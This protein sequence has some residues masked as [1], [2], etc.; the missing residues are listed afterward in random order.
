LISGVIFKLES[1][2]IVVAVVSLS[3]D[4]PM[5][6]SCIH[7]TNN[8]IS[9]SPL[10]TQGEMPTISNLHTYAKNIYYV[11]YASK[12]SDCERCSKSFQNMPLNNICI[13]LELIGY[14]SL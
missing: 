2:L 11:R 1:V 8:R 3:N 14:Y 7:R 13:Y 5:L 4:S 10:V 12:E 9:Y 6:G